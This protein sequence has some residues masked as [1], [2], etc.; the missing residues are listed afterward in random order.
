[1]G[2]HPYEILKQVADKWA[3]EKAHSPKRSLRAEILPTLPSTRGEG[4]L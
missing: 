4:N 1:M 3:A 2:A